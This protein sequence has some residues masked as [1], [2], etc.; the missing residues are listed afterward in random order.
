MFN[1][2]LLMMINEKTKIIDENLKISANRQE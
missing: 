1:P 2:S